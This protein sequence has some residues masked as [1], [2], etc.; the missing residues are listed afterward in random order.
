MSGP[1]F[2]VHADL[3]ASEDLLEL[4]GDLSAMLQRPAFERAMRSPIFR[5]G[6]HALLVEVGGLKALALAFEEEELRDL[7]ERDAPDGSHASTDDGECDDERI[8]A[9]I[10]SLGVAERA[11]LTRVADD[12]RDA[13]VCVRKIVDRGGDAVDACGEITRAVSVALVRGKPSP[14]AA[15]E[16][17]IG[18]GFEVD[19]KTVAHLRAA[20]GPGASDRAGFNAAYRDHLVSEGRALG[21][22]VK[23]ARPVPLPRAAAPTPEAELTDD[24]EAARRR[25]VTGPSSFGDALTVGAALGRDLA[26]LDRRLCNEAMACARDRVAR[27]AT[28]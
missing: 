25:L 1:A 24:E 22:Q 6:A 18:G 8:A 10:E 3:T 27:G 16:A 2:R 26:A 20:L 11:R 19:A 17:S 21:E 15:V 4:A 12:Y 7:R 9:T 28:A 23:P 5:H 14:A 13:L